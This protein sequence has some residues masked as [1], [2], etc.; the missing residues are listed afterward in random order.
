MRCV[1]SRGHDQ[2]AVVTSGGGGGVVSRNLGKQTDG[3]AGGQEGREDYAPSD[4]L[5][6]R[7]HHFQPPGSRR[8]V[9]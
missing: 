8:T 6:S 5:P 3:R 1:V 9:H 7:Y 2:R 4:R